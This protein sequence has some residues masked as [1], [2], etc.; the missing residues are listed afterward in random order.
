MQAL[1]AKTSIAATRVVRARL[2]A[3]A[4]LGGLLGAA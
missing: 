1:S 3:P 4:A 2:A